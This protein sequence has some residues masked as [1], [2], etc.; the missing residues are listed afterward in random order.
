MAKSNKNFSDVSYS[1]K[2]GSSTCH[3]LSRH[4]K[5]LKYNNNYHSL[6]EDVSIRCKSANVSRTSSPRSQRSNSTQRFISR[7]HRPKTSHSCTITTDINLRTKQQQQQQQILNQIHHRRYSPLKYKKTNQTP[8]KMVKTNQKVLTDKF[9]QETTKEK[10][11]SIKKKK[12]TSIETTIDNQKQEIIQIFNEQKQSLTQLLEQHISTIT[13]SSINIIK[14]IVNETLESQEHISTKEFEHTLIQ[15][16]QQELQQTLSKNIDK[17][18]TNSFDVNTLNQLEDILIQTIEKYI[19]TT[20]KNDNIAL[21]N[22]FIEQKQV[23]VDTLTQQRSTPSIDLIKQAVIDALREHNSRSMTPNTRT[24][25]TNHRKSNTKITN[26]EVKIAAN[27]NQT[28]VDA[29]FRQQRDTIVVNR[30]L[31]DTVRKWTNVR[32]ISSLVNKIQACGTNDF[33]NAW[34]L[35]CWIGQNISHDIYCQN[36]SAE[37]V[38]QNRIGSCQGFVNLYYECCLLLNIQCLKISGYIRENFLKKNEDLKK[39]THSWNAIVLDQ[40]TYLVD[41]TWSVSINHNTNQI[42]DYYFLTSSEEFIY[43][44]YSTDYQLLQP[45]ITKQEFLSLPIIKSNY[46]RLNLSLLAPKQGYNQTDENI[47]KISI[48]TPAYVD[49]YASL[50]ID[51]IEYPCHLYTLCQ[52]D[53]YQT[54]TINCFLAPP[55]NGLYEIRIYAKTNNETTYQDSI[56]MQLNVLNMIQAITFPIIYQSFFE[57]KCILIEPFRRL[58]KKNEYLFIHM[59]I[60]DAILIKIKNG[61]DYIIPNKDEYK[62]GLLKKEIYIQGDLHICAQWNDKTNRQISTI[63]IFNMI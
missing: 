27:L 2:I 61:D 29:A 16:I 42:Q 21:N 24:N 57:Y 52:R 6:P 35:F 55:T 9:C 10:H 39:C 60:P 13:T 37:N 62:N 49:L 5:N 26:N 50:K 23:L 53:I 19:A 25:I 34:L 7:E 20:N 15:A 28:R 38:F 33:E 46:Y 32:S 44:H 17:S 22:L 11:S 18:Q 8:D 30:Y 54:D 41:P 48:K 3:V 47:F 14:Q 1:L 12:K 31:R 59:K 40:Y 51:N 56:Y 4:M 58:I 45:K 36:N 63:C 43:T